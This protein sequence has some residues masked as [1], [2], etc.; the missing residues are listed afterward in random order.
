[1]PSLVTAIALFRQSSATVPGLRSVK[2]KVIAI[3]S[4]GLAP[5][6]DLALLA[7]YRRI[8]SQLR[9][10]AYLGWTIKP[11]DDDPTWQPDDNLPNGPQTMTD[12]T[13]LPDGTLLLTNGA[14]KGSAGGY[15]ADEPATQALQ[16][17]PTSPKGTR[18][19]KLERSEIPRLYHSVSILLPS[20]E[21]L[22]AGSNPDVF[23]A[24]KGNVEINSIYPQ[25]WNNG[26][27]SYLRCSGCP[28]R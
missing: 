11:N 9:P 2:P 4:K 1:M 24:A 10:A 6:R 13:L 17:D 27:I 20:G 28:L 26:K 16:Y 21:V 12:G 25:F 7:A 18:F 14:H 3:D 22:I 19:T 8:F 23:Y 5:H 15:M